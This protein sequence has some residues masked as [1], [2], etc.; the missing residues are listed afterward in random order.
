VQSFSSSRLQA[1]LSEHFSEVKTS[2]HYFADP[3]QLNWKGRVM[4]FAKSAAL[5]VGNCGS[6]ETFFFEASSA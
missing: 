6:G 2:R 3:E 1:L 4:Y 5:R